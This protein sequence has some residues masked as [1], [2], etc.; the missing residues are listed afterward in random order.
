MKF[1]KEMKTEEGKRNVSRIANQM[2][3]ERQDVVGLSC[4]KSVRGEI[5]TDGEEIKGVTLLVFAIFTVS[6]TIIYW[7]SIILFPN[8]DFFN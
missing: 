1:A 3:K 4:L 7:I 5:V 6:T 2:T 8:K